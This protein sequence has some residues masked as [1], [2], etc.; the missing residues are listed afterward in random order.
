MTEINQLLSKLCPGRVP[1]RKLGS[2]GKF[3]GGLT[4]KTK[5]DFKDGNANSLHIATCIV[6]LR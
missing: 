2:L 1:Y 6:I 4:G 5:H 3:Y